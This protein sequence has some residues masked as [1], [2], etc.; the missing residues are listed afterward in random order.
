MLALWLRALMLRAPRATAPWCVMPTATLVCD[1]HCDMASHR[2]VRL[3]Q[4]QQLQL[5]LLLGLTFA[6]FVSGAAATFVHVKKGADGVWWLERGGKQLFSTGVSNLNDGGHD[7]GVGGVLAAPCQQQENSTLCGDTNNWDMQLGYSPYF[8]VTQALF[9]RSSLDW[10]TDAAGRL[11]SWGFNTISGYSSAV[12]E[13]AVAARGM[14]YTHLVR[15]K[16][17][18]WNLRSH[19]LPLKTSRFCVLGRA[20]D[21]RHALRRARGHAAPAE[22]RGRL[23]RSGHLQRG[24]RCVRGCLRTGQ[25]AAPGQRPGAARLAL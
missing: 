25:R 3:P 12:A 11:S 19:G 17:L 23:L 15:S 2:R 9:N 21:V 14:L 8:N 10:A 13:Q 4:L 5:L 16:T 1:A 18:S 7:D 20:A 22:H 24:V 6:T